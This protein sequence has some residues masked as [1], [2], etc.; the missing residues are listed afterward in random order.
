MKY[1][2]KKKEKRKKRERNTLMMDTNKTVRFVFSL[3]YHSIRYVNQ[4]LVKK[5][6]DFGIMDYSFFYKNIGIQ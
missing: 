4:P 1:N 3:S 5:N 2:A 6:I